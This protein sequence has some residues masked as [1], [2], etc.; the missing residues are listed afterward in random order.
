MKYMNLI[1]N[2]YIPRIVSV[3][4]IIVRGILISLPTYISG[5]INPR[6]LGIWVTKIPQSIA[7]DPAFGWLRSR[8]VLT[9][10]P[11]TYNPFFPIH[12]LRSR[13]WVT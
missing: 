2:F 11:L 13:S 6:F 1:I 5:T 9:K 4:G 8:N 7:Y 10:I 3:T 12:W